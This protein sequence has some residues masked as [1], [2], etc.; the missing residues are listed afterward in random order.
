MRAAVQWWP[1]PFERLWLRGGVGVGSQASD[2]SAEAHRYTAY[3]TA[4]AA[5]GVEVVRSY[6]FTMDL[7]VQ[8]AATKEPN[9][10]GRSVSL[11]LGFNWY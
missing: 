8:G 10:W 5:V 11:N 4:L 2:D 7:Q 6:R 1:D 3:P 9:R